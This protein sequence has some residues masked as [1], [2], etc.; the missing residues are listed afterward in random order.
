MDVLITGITGFV[1]RH[2]AKELVERD[3]EVSGIMRYVSDRDTSDLTDIPLYYADIIDTTALRSIF[4]EV[5][6]DIV[7][8]L[9]TQSSVEFSFNNPCEEY[10]VG[11]IGTVNVAQAVIETVPNLKKFIFA[12]SVEVYG[13]QKSFPIK[14]TAPV[15]PA[16]SYG[17]AKVAAEY[18]F[19]YLYESSG[20]PCIIFRSTNTF[21]RKYNHNFV[22]E[23]II[24]EM[25]NKKKVLMGES[26]SIRDFLYIDD[27]TDAYIKVIET[28]KDIFNETINTGTGRGVTIR[29]LTE[30]IGNLIGFNGEIEWNKISHR[31]CEIKNLTIDASKLNKLLGWAPKYTLEEG[32][33]KTIEWWTRE[34]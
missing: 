25:L 33:E 15:K 23:H 31:P 24:Y 26:D 3:Y 32:L 13:N 34:K 8:H 16:S 11:F 6:P 22:I 12:S 18:H 14:E 10:Q 17:V 19:K 9:A 20:F 21:G 30:I 29:E 27:E 1:G 2:L 4:R 28:E 7:I 5:K